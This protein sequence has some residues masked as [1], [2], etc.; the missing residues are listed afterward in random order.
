MRIKSNFRDYYDHIQQYVYG[1]SPIYTRAW[2][3]MSKSYYDLLQNSNCFG[4]D[5]SF[6]IGFCGKIYGG[7]KKLIEKKID[8]SVRWDIKHT[9]IYDHVWSLEQWAEGRRSFNYLSIENHKKCEKNFFVKEDD[10]IFIKENS[11]IFYVNKNYSVCCP[12]NPQNHEK[13]DQTLQSCHFEQKV[14]PE[15]A[16]TSL[17]SFIGFLGMEHKTIPEMS[18]EVKVKSHGFDKHSFRH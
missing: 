10:S 7:I 5:Y 18:N 12:L 16:Y 14:S 11:P 9:Y 8:R 2:C 3:S 17:V 1:E 4:D 13:F 15:E 6:V